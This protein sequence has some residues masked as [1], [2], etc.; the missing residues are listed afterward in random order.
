[1]VYNLPTQ[2]LRETSGDLAGLWVSVILQ[3]LIVEGDQEVLVILAHSLT[4]VG[5]DTAV[6]QDLCHT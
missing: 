2:S 3:E 4:L 6:K 5:G 1:M